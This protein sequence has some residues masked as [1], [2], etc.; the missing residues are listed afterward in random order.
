MYVPAITG[1]SRS[2][3]NT[4][5]HLNLVVTFNEMRWNIS[6]ATWSV[7]DG[8]FAAGAFNT[9]P[10]FSNRTTTSSSDIVTNG[11]R[12]IRLPFFIDTE[13]RSQY[14]GVDGDRML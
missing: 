6:S 9:S 12:A 3:Y 13:R 1:G 14:E 7:S 10:N 11:I 8:G 2:Q 5:G 4:M